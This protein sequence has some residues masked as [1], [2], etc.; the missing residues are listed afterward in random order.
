MNVGKGNR[1]IV[2]PIVKRA[3]VREIT[4]ESDPK[5]DAVFLKPFFTLNNGCRHSTP[6]PPKPH[7]TLFIFASR[8]AEKPF[9]H[10][11]GHCPVEIYSENGHR[12]FNNEASFTGIESTLEILIFCEFFEWK[13]NEK[14]FWYIKPKNKKLKQ[15]L[16]HQNSG[17]TLH[18]LQF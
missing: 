10:Y 12:L 11:Q 17:P 15:I 8:L 14:L 2:I 1:W 9:F 13:E 4:S 7:S 18:C 6:S 5:F 16:D 3:L